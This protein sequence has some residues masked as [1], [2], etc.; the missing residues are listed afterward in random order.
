MRKDGSIVQSSELDPKNGNVVRHFTHKGFSDHT[1]WG[2]A[3]AWGLVYAAIAL[4][5]RPREKRWM[6]QL[7][8]AADWW[9]AKAPPGMVV[10]WDFD[11]PAIPAT[12]TD[13]AATSI[14][15]SS[16]LK[17]AQLAPT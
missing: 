17:L 9:L 5:H 10:F 12:E 13:T 6:E 7:L 11:D 4:A 14:A 3:Q 1:V 16:L 8:K 15:C 2:R